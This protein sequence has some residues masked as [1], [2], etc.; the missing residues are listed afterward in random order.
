MNIELL[1]TRMVSYFQNMSAEDLVEKYKKLGYS[2]SES[3]EQSPTVV[4]IGLPSD[5]QMELDINHIIDS[6]ANH[7]RIVEL[8]KSYMSRA[9]A[10]PEGGDTAAAENEE[11][12][13]ELER[14]K[15]LLYNMA[16]AG[17]I[18]QHTK[19]YTWLQFKINNN[20]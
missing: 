9:A 19:D 12:R 8:F 3:L 17:S 7:I 15:G 18:G 10:S 11:L 2:F 13:K 20:L 14:V 4:G 16:T 6:G 1:R 5:K